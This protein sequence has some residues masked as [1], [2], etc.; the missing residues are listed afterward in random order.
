MVYANANY[1]KFTGMLYGENIDVSATTFL[2][3]LNNQFKFGKGWSG[4]VSGFYRSKGV[5]G[6]IVIEPLG[7]ASAAIS[8][9]LFKEKAN[10]K[11]GMR[12]IFYTQQV[13]G[14]INFQETEATFHNSRDSRQVSLT[15]TYRFGKPI[16]GPQP[17]RNAGG[18]SDEANRVKTGGNN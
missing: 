3:N 1:N 4:E 7:Q 12:D 8:K 13:K 9:Q 2:A 16:K 14:Y 6:Q 18:A 17:R 10:I 11:L 15:F 5:E